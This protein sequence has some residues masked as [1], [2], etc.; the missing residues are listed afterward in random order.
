M[1]VLFLNTTLQNSTGKLG[2][3]YSTNDVIHIM[4][5]K[6]SICSNRHYIGDWL[7]GTWS[8][9]HVKAGGESLLWSPGQLAWAMVGQ[10]CRLTSGPVHRWTLNNMTWE[11]W[12]MLRWLIKS[13]SLN[14]TNKLRSSIHPIELVAAISILYVL[15]IQCEE[16]GEVYKW[17]CLLSLHDS[18]P[19]SPSFPLMS[20]GVPVST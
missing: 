7:W 4:I 10:W 6:I 15:M 2:L 20:C 18:H 17:V 5:L 16:E 1:P 9:V 8:W 13:L 12:D 19:R 11:T 3:L 14:L